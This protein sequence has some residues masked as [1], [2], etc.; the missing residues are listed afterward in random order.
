[1]RNIFKW[2]VTVSSDVSPPLL[3]PAALCFSSVSSLPL[4]AWPSLAGHG[5]AA[6]WVPLHVADAPNGLHLRAASAI[7]VKVSIVALLQ[8]V[9]AATVAGVLV[10]H[11][12]ERQKSAFRA[13]CYFWPALYHLT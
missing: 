3:P 10:A 5:V 7:L 1:M 6:M 2:G 13:L 4:L 12:A 9:L 11:P 8:Q